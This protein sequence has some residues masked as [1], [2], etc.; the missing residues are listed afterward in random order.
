MK[1]TVQSTAAAVVLLT[2]LLVDFAGATSK[3]V[4]PL[5]DVRHSN[6][7]ANRHDALAAVVGASEGTYRYLY[8]CG[9]V[10]TTSGYDIL[11]LKYDSAGAAIQTRQVSVGQQTVD[12]ACAIIWV[13][14]NT[15][16]YIYVLGTTWNGSD[17]DY[18]V[19]K[20]DSTLT[21]SW[22]FTL[23]G[24]LNLADEAV[25]MA[26]SIEGGTPYLYVTGKSQGRFGGTVV[27]YDVM[28]TKLTTGGQ[29]V[30]NWPVRLDLS[31]T[32][33]SEDE[34]VSIAV[35]AIC[36]YVGGTTRPQS[37][38]DT[39]I[40]T[41]AFTLAG[42]RVDVGMYGEAGTGNTPCA[43]LVR[44]RDSELEDVYVIGSVEQTDM[45]YAIMPYTTEYDPEVPEY[46]FTQGDVTLRDLDGDDEAVAAEVRAVGQTTDLYLCGRTEGDF[47][48]LRYADDDGL[49][50]DWTATYD[51]GESDDKPA[52]M[53]V[54]VNGCVYAAGTVDGEDDC[55]NSDRR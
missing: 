6:S 21:E 4:W 37:E 3:T 39:D 13:R 55:D 40:F 45:D 15:Y 29:Q 35:G 11:V 2:V 49:T 46:T 34:P 20:Y 54:D 38:T 32:E 16:P 43:V 27:N 7:G 42:A 9:K 25:A 8:A 53:C 30:T 44:P 33:A 10:W 31:D 52:A 12:S 23:D 28:T 18:V 5:W 1:R 17:A 24:G 19:V 47:A 26:Y 22:R 48:A 50:E 36:W 14:E 41:S 51:F